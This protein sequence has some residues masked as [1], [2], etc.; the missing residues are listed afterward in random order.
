MKILVTR[1]REGKIVVRDKTISSI[2]V[3]IAVFAGI[4]K[5]DTRAVIEKMAKKI[6]TLRIFKNEEGK[7]RYSV[8]NMN[9]QI[10]CV[11]NFTLCANS[12]KGNRPSF[13]GAMPP[14]EANEL[15]ELFVH[16][17]KGEELDVK[18]GIFG[19]HMDILLNLDGPVNIVLEG[20]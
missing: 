3:G 18:T 19:E 8:K 1:V 2:K 20:K 7:M 16:I 17:L 14:K 12:K 5:N 4:E 10:L 13:D 9:Y 15:F 6:V 11:S